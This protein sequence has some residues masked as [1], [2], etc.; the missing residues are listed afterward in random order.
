ML[1]VIAGVRTRQTPFF[2]CTKR[3]LDSNTDRYAVIPIPITITIT[4]TIT[5]NPPW[6]RM[7][8]EFTP[9]FLWSIVLFN[10]RVEFLDR[11]DMKWEAGLDRQVQ[12][13]WAS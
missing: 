9:I 10:R 11:S 1:T 4:I 2:F 12:W 8:T 5:M 3:I 6:F 13:V 7:G